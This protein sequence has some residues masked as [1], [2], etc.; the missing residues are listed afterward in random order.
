MPGVRG[1]RADE[2]AATEWVDWPVFRATVLDGSR[3]VSPWCVE[4]VRLLPPD[5]V[6][7]PVQPAHL[8]PPAAR[9]NGTLGHSGVVPGAHDR[10][11]SGRR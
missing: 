5:P 1:A 3:D 4:Q 11:D 2:V 8:L 9:S 6:D 7:A 10:D